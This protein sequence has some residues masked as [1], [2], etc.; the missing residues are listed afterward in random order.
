MLGA[1]VTYRRLTCLCHVLYSLYMQLIICIATSMYS[2]VKSSEST[3]SACCT[4]TA[5]LFTTVPLLSVGLDCDFPIL[6]A[7]GHLF[8]S[9]CTGTFLIN[10]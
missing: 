10:S 8:N 3:I 6:L 4:F 2:N 1:R 9:I 5:T 7:C